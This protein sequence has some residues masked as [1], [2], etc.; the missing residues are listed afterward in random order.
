MLG[1]KL[2]RHQ[3]RV[4]QFAVVGFVESNGKRLDRCGVEARHSG[5]N[6]GRIDSST[7]KGADRNIAHEMAG[8]R[9]FQQLPQALDKIIVP[10]NAVRLET[11]I[12]IAASCY[13]K[14]LREL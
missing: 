5:H 1:G 2:L 10:M 9:F 7:E 12:P 11:Q 8:D 13:F 3:P 4:L 14:R 6:G